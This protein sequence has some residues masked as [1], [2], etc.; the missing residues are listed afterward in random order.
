MKDNTEQTLEWIAIRKLLYH[1]PN[2]EN[3]S[4]ETSGAI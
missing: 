2:L 3:N 1:A 4:G